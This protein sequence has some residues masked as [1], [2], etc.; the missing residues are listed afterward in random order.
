VS[1]S[2]AIS[3]I[4]A[5]I[6]ISSIF[7]P[8]MGSAEDSSCATW[9]STG[10]DP[11]QTSNSSFIV[12]KVPN[13]IVWEVNAVVYYGMVMAEDGTLYGGLANGSLISVSPSGHVNW[14]I[15][16]NGSV[17]Y[18]PIIGSDGSI[19]FI[20]FYSRDGENIPDPFTIWMFKVNA[21]G[22]VVARSMIATD[23]NQF[24]APTI[25]PAGNIIVCFKKNVDGDRKITRGIICYDNNLENVWTYS[26]DF[27]ENTYNSDPDVQPTISPDSSITIVINDTYVHFSSDGKILWKYSPG[28]YDCWNPYYYFENAQ[29]RYS[30][31]SDDNGRLYLGFD[32][33]G[34]CL[35]PNGTEAWRCHF[36]CGYVHPLA[37]SDDCVYFTDSTNIAI[38]SRSGEFRNIISDIDLSIDLIW[39]NDVIITSGRSIVF[40]GSTSIGIFLDDSG[41]NEIQCQSPNPD[42]TAEWGV[43]SCLVAGNDT[44]CYQTVSNE[45]GKIVM[46][47]YVPIDT[48]TPSPTVTSTATS[49]IDTVQLFLIVVTI[50]FVIFGLSY[51]IP[52]KQKK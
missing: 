46:M 29:K 4:L 1:R 13:T 25:T 43:W 32:D 37:L 26:E 50:G 33:Y 19:F 27:I 36:V 38:A 39:N 23:T 7:I 21:E 35:Y 45:Y 41:L 3:I 6:M 24:S 30:V 28:T 16:Y 11:E 49:S 5:A 22:D 14:C 9:P 34:I 44:I 20:S 31:I 17:V 48:P 40:V 12:D 2:T 18:S 52:K 10:G 8:A 15:K 47:T 51:I 42:S